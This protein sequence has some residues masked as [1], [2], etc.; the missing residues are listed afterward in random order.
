MRQSVIICCFVMVAFLATHHESC[1]RVSLPEIFSDNMVL[2]RNQEIK[3]WGWAEDKEKITVT[4]N[5]QV[6]STITKSNGRWSL[7]LSP[8]EAGG[9]YEMKIA[10]QDTV[11]LQNILIGEVWLC[12]G[13]SNMAWPVRR[14]MNA[15]AEI[16]NAYY[17][18]IRFF[19][20]PHEMKPLPAIDY[21]QNPSWKACSPETAAGFS[22]VA[23]FFGRE[24]HEKLTV[25]IGLI[26]AS[27]GGSEVEAWT[28]H[29]ALEQQGLFEE[30]LARMKNLDLEKEQKESHQ[31]IKDWEEAMKGLDKGIK[32][33]E[34]IWANNNCDDIL[35]WKGMYLPSLFK[36]THLRDFEGGIWFK[37]YINLTAEDT[38]HDYTLILGHIDDSDVT[39]INNE[40]VG[41]TFNRSWALRE[42]KIPKD[43]LRKGRNCIAI[44]MEDYG[45]HGGF[46]GKQEQFQL[47]SEHRVIT[48]AGTWYY[49]I[50]F[51][52]VPEYPGNPLR[53]N[54]LAGSLF[55]GMIHP[56]IPFTI[57]GVIWYQGEANANRGYQY[58]T[59]FPL[60]IHDWRNKWDKGEFP[61]LFVQ[62]ANYMKALER[63]AESNWAELREA[64]LLTLKKVPNT[65][66]AVIID[67]GEADDIH[68]Q[69]K[70]EVGY[71]LSLAA[72][73]KAYGEDIVY[74]GPIYRSMI[75]EENKI[76]IS[77]DHVGGG[78][79]IQGKGEDLS[80]FAIAGK[81]KKFKWAKAEIV[82]N[83]V[84]VY[85]DSISHPLA[86]RYAWANNPEKANLYNKEGLPASPF[87]T[88]EWKGE[89]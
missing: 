61:F 13:Q 83:E 6:K 15:K 8:L 88:D 12:S 23:Y 51:D 31:K 38:A 58:R 63:P 54:D 27:W 75:I 16:K 3:I 22:A 17:P 32:N 85:H 56:L 42:Y 30:E 7:T 59:L 40:K 10:G 35:E 41:E 78:L 62:L 81:N 18:G 37:R 73:A 79:M 11:T 84:I 47:E 34:Y 1:A 26:D 21:D 5:H 46:S 65:G 74:S 19:S 70:Q 80:G 87:R 71:R 9:P 24:L 2:Q 57:Q 55:N 43:L 33:G 50:G 52:S 69:N 4:F 28:S 86:V 76:R 72:R 89:K 67:I 14:S 60:M 77:F 64:Q 48:L 82:N 29:E 66:M 25:P 49:K 53:P 39:F 44:R 45:Q 36:N 20:S 68:P